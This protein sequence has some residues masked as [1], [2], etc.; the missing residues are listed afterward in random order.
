MGETR[1]SN[2]PILE[3]N[4][5]WVRRVGDE[6]AMSNGINF[7]MTHPVERLVVNRAAG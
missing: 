3:K 1:G 7:H 6:H 5:M 4:A 2:Q